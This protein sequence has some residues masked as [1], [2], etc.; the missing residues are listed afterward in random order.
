MEIL[1]NTGITIA[2][3]IVLS[4][5][6]LEIFFNGYLQT[7]HYGKFI[8]TC[9]FSPIIVSFVICVSIGLYIGKII[10]KIADEKI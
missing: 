10:N 8:L 7:K 1:L 9:I 6:T 4:T 2:V 3:Y 5:I